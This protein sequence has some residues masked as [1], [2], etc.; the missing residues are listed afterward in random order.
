M[1]IDTKIQKIVGG[2]NIKEIKHR[3]KTI[4][5]RTP[6][7]L[8]YYKNK[9]GAAIYESG[10]NY[11]TSLLLEKEKLY[12]IKK[13]EKFKTIFCWSMSRKSSMQVEVIFNFDTIYQEQLTGRYIDDLHRYQYNFYFDFDTSLLIGNEFIN[14]FEMRLN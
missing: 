3:D 13:D 7:Y 4:W 8:L 11:G 10:F 9:S 14:T 12:Y 6:E 1:L 5:T 2:H